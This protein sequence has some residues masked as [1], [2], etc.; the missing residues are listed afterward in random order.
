MILIQQQTQIL[1]RQQIHLVSHTTTY[2]ILQ[3]EICTKTCFMTVQTMYL[4]GQDM[5]QQLRSW[6]SYNYSFSLELCFL[7]FLGLEDLPLSL[8]LSS[9]SFSRIIFV[10][11]VEG[12]ESNINLNTVSDS[13]S[14]GPCFFS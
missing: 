3:V 6:L 5:V 11:S 1:I 14:S 9:F 7:Y 13:I 2:T 10:F 4:Y 8:L 12:N